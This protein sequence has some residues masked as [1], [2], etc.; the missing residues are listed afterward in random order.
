MKR[1][2]DLSRNPVPGQYIPWCNPDGSFYWLQCYSSFCFCVD[3]DGNEFRAT[4]LDNA[5]GRPKCTE[6]GNM[7]WVFREIV[8]KIIKMDSK[9]YLNLSILF[10]LGPDL[11]SAINNHIVFKTLLL[12]VCAGGM[13][14]PCQRRYQQAQAN[15]G[16][17]APRCRA[18]GSFEEVQCDRRNMFCW[19]VDQF[20][21]QIPRTRSRDQVRCP[22]LGKW[23][24][25]K[26]E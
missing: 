20:G 25:W 17:Y 11:L 16:A 12:S 3:K 24:F 5:A 9:C 6:R 8:K 21:N 22:R 15:P 18:D 1:Y 10:L 23:T 26:N 14:T 4:R 2:I 13:L 7:L 19:C